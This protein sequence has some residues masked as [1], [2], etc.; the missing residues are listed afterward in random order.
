MTDATREAAFER[1]A[2]LVGRKYATARVWFNAGWDA[3]DADVS[4]LR[5]AARRVYEWGTS[6]SVYE[7]EMGTDE[8][9]ADLNGDAYFEA[10]R[11]AL[12]AFPTEEAKG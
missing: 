10:L 9:I 8:T 12:A 2:T 4:A 5:E 3:R 11:A 6:D 7:P 1:A